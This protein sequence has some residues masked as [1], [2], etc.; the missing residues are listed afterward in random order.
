MRALLFVGSCFLAIVGWSTVAFGEDGDTPADV[1]LNVVL[2]AAGQSGRADA[3]IRIHATRD[4]VW[5]L[6]TSCPES[7]N[8]VPGLVG[9]DV[10]ETAPDQSWQKIRHVL[11]YSWFIPK[12]T[13]ELRATYDK[14]ERVTV[15]RTGGDVKAL[16]VQWTLQ[17][18]GDYTIARYVIDLAPGFWVPRWLV[19][20]ALRRDLPKMLL[21]LR[22]RAET[23]QNR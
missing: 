11:D 22:N 21:A 9:C 8:L 16:S 12:L 15:V 17:A 10:L 18:D 19:R 14:P 2:D 4:T 13:Y 3:T 7:L 1:Q 5:S 23:L 20:G 6:V